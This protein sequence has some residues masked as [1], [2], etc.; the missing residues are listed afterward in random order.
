MEYNFFSCQYC[1]VIALTQQ[2]RNFSPL[3]FAQVDFTFSPTCVQCVQEDPLTMQ[4]WRLNKLQN[5]TTGFLQV[6]A[7]IHRA[8]NKAL[9]FAAVE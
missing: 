4:K 8:E 9:K 2:L 5:I 6:L 1:K 7:A 3:T